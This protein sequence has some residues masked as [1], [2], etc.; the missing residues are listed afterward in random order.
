MEILEYYILVNTYIMFFWIF[1][2]I[3]LKYEPVFQSLR[4]YLMAS[5]MVSILLPFL[6]IS[7][8]SFSVIYNHIPRDMGF[9]E[10]PIRPPD[11]L[12]PNAGFTLTPGVEYELIL[13]YMIL[14]GSFMFLLLNLFKH[15]KIHSLVKKSDG[16]RYKN[17]NVKMISKPIIPLLYNKSILIPNTISQEE[18]K[19]VI[20]HEYQHFRLGH[21]IDNFLL[22]LFQIIFWVNPF[23]YLLMRDLKQIH[24]YQADKEIIE[25]GIDASIYKLTLIK[26]SVGFQKFAIANGLSN[27]KIKNRLIMMNIINVRKWKWKFLLFIPAFFVVFLFLSF[28]TSDKNALLHSNEQQIVNNGKIELTTISNEEIRALRAANNRDYIIL[29]INHKSQL[30]LNGNEK[31]SFDE[32]IEKVSNSFKIK[33]SEVYKEL[34]SDLLSN[35]SSKIAFVIQKS[36]YTDQNDYDKLLDHVSKSIFNLQEIYSYE[37]YGKSY[38]I[39]DSSD[40]DVLKNLIQPRIYTL[41]DKNVIPGNVTQK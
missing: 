25:S 1:F 26:Y 36:T 15:A 16:I 8:P 2:H 23:I 6:H 3:I 37:L 27:Y 41:P 18:M 38:S 32:V 20:E 5:L 28:T 34:N 10:G 29:M 12:F 22:Q 31:P 9:I 7:L 13:K 30:L 39:L 19:I 4:I 14:S 40:K 35:A 11:Y 33:V 21:Y 24:E 17:L